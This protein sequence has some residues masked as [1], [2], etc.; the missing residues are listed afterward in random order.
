[1][2]KVL[3]TVSGWLDATRETLSGALPEKAFGVINTIELIGIVASVFVLVS[4]LMKDIRV[5]RT[6]GIVACIVFVLYGLLLGALSIWLLNGIL[7]FV[8]LYYLI[9]AR[10]GSR[11]K[12]P[13]DNRRL[14]KFSRTAFSKKGLRDLPWFISS[15]SD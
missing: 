3:D 12:T 6:I 10:K 14:G 15:D 2:K 7:I 1:M 4:F 9:R 13:S 11:D 5:I 8:H